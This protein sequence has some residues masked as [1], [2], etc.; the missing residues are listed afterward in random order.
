MK[1]EKKKAQFLKMTDKMNGANLWSVSGK[2]RLRQIHVETVKEILKMT[3]HMD[4]MG[5][6]SK[7]VN[8]AF[9]NTKGFITAN[10]NFHVIQIISAGLSYKAYLF[11]PWQIFA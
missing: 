1:K 2:S 9:L 8:V 10:C 5:M 3:R 7:M 4:W 6:M 11:L